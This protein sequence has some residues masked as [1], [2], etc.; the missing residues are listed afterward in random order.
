MWSHRDGD[1]KPW[2]F[3][4]EDGREHSFTRY[5]AARAFACVSGTIKDL[6]KCATKYLDADPPEAAETVLAAVKRREEPEN[7][8]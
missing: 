5:S 2:V 8:V 3:T 1:E 4:S 7:P 6:T